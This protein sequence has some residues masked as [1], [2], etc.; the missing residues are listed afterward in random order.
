MG[1]WH[2]VLT[3]DLH[4]VH[5][6]NPNPSWSLISQYQYCIDTSPAPFSFYTLFLVQLTYRWNWKLHVGLNTA[7]INPT[8]MERLISQLCHWNMDRR[9]SLCKSTQI[10]IDPLA[11]C[12]RVIPF[13]TIDSFHLLWQ[14]YD[15]Y[16]RF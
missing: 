16:S 2:G 11:D 3:K 7:I 4:N 10:G 13:G 1:R 14:F 6:D 12:G 15:H 8:K 5:H 9:K